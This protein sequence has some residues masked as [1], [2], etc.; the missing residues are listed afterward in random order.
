MQKK[1][2]V[3]DLDETLFCGREEALERKV[4]FVVLDKY[5]IYLCPYL[6]EFLSYAFENF[7]VGVWT[8]LSEDY[9]KD[10]LLR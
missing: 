5:Y 9:A 2:L 1:L 10:D 3:L 8:S 6:S 4:G 7:M